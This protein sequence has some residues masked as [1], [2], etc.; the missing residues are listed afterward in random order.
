MSKRK[1][2]FI[3]RTVAISLL[4]TY[5]AAAGAADTTLSTDSV[6]RTTAATAAPADTTAAQPSGEG[7]TLDEFVVTARK[8]LVE[9]DGAKLTYNVEEDPQAQT[10]PVMDILRKVPGVSVDAEDNIRVNGQSS[11][12]IF[13]NGREDP[14]MQGDVKQILKAMP[15]SSIKKI[16]VISDPGAKYEAEGVGGILNI[17]TVTRQRLAGFMVNANLWGGNSGIGAYVG[18]RTKVKNVTADLSVS[19]NNGHLFRRYADAK[20][21]TENLEA[22]QPGETY[23]RTSNKHLRMNNYDYASVRLN[24]SWEPDTLNLFTLSGNLSVNNWGNPFTETTVGTDIEGTPLWRYSRRTLEQTGNWRGGSIMASYQH[25]FGAEGAH[26]LVLSYSYSNNGDKSDFLMDTYDV[27]NYHNLDYIYSRS[28]SKGFSDTHIAQADYSNPFAKWITFEAGAKG[29]F[30]RNHNHSEGLYGMEL[31]SLAPKEDTE[32]RANQFRD[33]IA[34]YVSANLSFSKIKGRVGMRYEHT[35]MGMR[36]P[37]GKAEDFTSNLN[38][39]VPNASATYNLT[40]AS[41]VRLAYQMRISRP[42]L[43]VM[44]PYIN[45]MTE[46]EIRY[47]N[48]DLKSE[49]MHRI[50]LSYSNYDHPLTGEVKLNYMYESNSITD[51]IFMYEGI[52]NTTYANVGKWQNLELET[53]LSW[54]PVTNLNLQLYYSITRNW[55]KADSELLHRSKQYWQDNLNLSAD[56]KF[57]CNIRLSGWGGYWSPWQDLQSKGQS[58]YY[59]GLGVSRSFLAEDALTIGINANTI[60]PK[61]RSNK[62]TQESANIRS[63]NYFRYPQWYVGASISY[64]FGGL[65]AQV[66]KTAANIESD[67]EAGGGSKGK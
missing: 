61:Y 4:L 66:K 6:A 9:S 65:K 54:S 39:L 53:N 18:A 43:G 26:N 62:Y 15:A 60:L 13:L 38:D 64:R 59:Y 49:K 44:N 28:L 29:T 30:F 34:A 42:S 37:D 51:I 48:P 67:S 47:G 23:A 12:K 3:C 33:I 1:K 21:S 50:T 57:P 36:Y 46:G 45:R 31:E 24:T 8:K 32:M 11:F 25:T 20:E 52:K 40:D 22:V 10:S 5:S 2:A 63:T 16:E 35:R 27:E 41:N 58:G 56:Y 19:Y 7:R 55:L 14:T 17:V